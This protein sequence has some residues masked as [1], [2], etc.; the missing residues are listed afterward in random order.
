MYELP[1]N[2]LLQQSKAQP[3]S[4]EELE[5]FGKVAAR[6]F[7]AGKHSTLSDAVVG[8][9][10]HAGLS[11][12]QV[13]RVVEFTNVN[14][15]ITEFNKEGS[16]NKYVQFE[17]GPANPSD[18]SRELNSG[19]GGT[20]FDRGNE[21]YRSM[22]SGTKTAMARNLQLLGLEKTAAGQSED[23]FWQAFYGDKTAGIETLRDPTPDVEDLYFKLAGAA[24]HVT[25]E[26]SLLEAEMPKVAED[27]HQAV[28]AG[29]H[30]GCTLG[31][32]L[33]AWTHVVPSPDYVKIAFSVIGPRLLEE[34]V[35]TADSFADSCEKTASQGLVN[36]EHPLVATM[37]HFSAQL[38]KCAQL[39]S[40]QQ[41]LIDSAEAVRRHPLFTGELH[42]EAMTPGF[43][44]QRGA[45]YLGNA[46]KNI[47]HAGNKAGEGAEWATKQLIG[48][49]STNKTTGGMLRD[50]LPGWANALTRG[51]VK[52]V[53]PAVGV[54][55]VGNELYDQARQIPALDTAAQVVAARTPGT[56]EYYMHQAQ[57]QQKQMENRGALYGG[58]Y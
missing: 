54:A 38:T 10:K 40:A 20:V 16:A 7:L 42:K 11:P 56:H 39:R 19:G 57:I 58:M 37:A 48:T 3:R 14:A 8:T 12:E 32:I 45:G 53:A 49:P 36:L 29:V 52:Y 51:T 2:V 28:R 22:P 50:E 27:L 21:D 17:G 47:A 30:D 44:I 1:A 34:G 6:S 5:T 55:A 15:Y 23:D 43:G 18:V 46:W 13:K 35:F 26:L 9:I 33:S 31:Q 25:S 41:E 4:G 24:D